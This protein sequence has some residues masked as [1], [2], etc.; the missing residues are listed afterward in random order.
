[1]ITPVSKNNQS[2]WLYKCDLLVIK[3]I[4]D[5]YRNRGIIRKAGTSDAD[6]KDAE[7][8]VRPDMQTLKIVTAKNCFWSCWKANKCSVEP[9]TI[10]HHPNPA[11]WTGG[12]LICI[13]YG[14]APFGVSNTAR[15]KRFEAA[16]TVSATAATDK[17]TQFNSNLKSRPCQHDTFH[18]PRYSFQAI[19]PA[20]F[21]CYLSRI[22]CSR[23]GLCA[24]L[25]VPL[26]KSILQ[27]IFRI[28]GIKR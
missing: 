2:T 17:H 9:L 28:Q 10:L 11:C 25:S 20:G 24:F 26:T 19:I 21:N 4:N 18:P 6:L 27:V 16:T 22:F 13:L 23:G 5:D 8:W 1:M 15:N 7:F 12:A 14:T 3:V